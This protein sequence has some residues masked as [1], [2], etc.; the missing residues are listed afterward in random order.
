M[1]QPNRK[2]LSLH[3]AMPS[4]SSS[5]S[6]SSSFSLPSPNSAHLPRIVSWMPISDSCGAEPSSI[7]LHRSNC[8]PLRPRSWG[9]RRRCRNMSDTESLV[10]CKRSQSTRTD[11]TTADES[12]SNRRVSFNEQ[13]TVASYPN[14]LNTA[15]IQAEAEAAEAASTSSRTMWWDDSQLAVE[16]ADDELIKRCT[17]QRT[18][19][20]ASRIKRKLGAIIAP[21]SVNRWPELQQQQQ[22]T[23]D[24]T[25]INTSTDIIDTFALFSSKIKKISKLFH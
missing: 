17:L 14:A 11:K 8:Q 5:V 10:K 20:S 12:G 21:G 2:R 3:S 13:V 22:Q 15:C 16:L 4:L 23:Y 24:S 9:E 19:S 18:P 7:G 6:S 1:S 25:T